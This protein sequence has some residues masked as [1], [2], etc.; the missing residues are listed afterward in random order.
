M[1]TEN[2]VTAIDKAIN[3]AKARKAAKV[4][5]VVDDVEKAAKKAE[6]EK[7]RAEAKAK[8]DAERENKKAEKASKKAMGGEQSAKKRAEKIPHLAKIK[9]AEELLP[10]LSED[11]AVQFNEFVSLNKIPDVLAFAAH[12]THF[13]RLQQTL[14]AST[15]DIVIT[16]NSKVRIIAGDPKY[17]GQ[18]GIVASMK[19]IR[20][21]VELADGKQVYCF[22]S[23]VEPIIDEQTENVDDSNEDVATGTDG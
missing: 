23:D 8:R 17:I 9:R 18:E 7:E 3:E 13:V 16:E 4:R 21:Y 5:P 6:R 1:T 20:C 15:D 12:L 10:T 22:T 14:K 19:R 11:L 2:S